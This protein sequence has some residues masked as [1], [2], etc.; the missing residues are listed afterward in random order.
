MDIDILKILQ[1]IKEA[2]GL[3]LLGLAIFWAVPRLAGA[4]DRN[5]RMI[6]NLANKLRI[7]PDSDVI[8]EIEGTPP[9]GHRKIT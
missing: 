2:G 6:Y 5:T 7:D 8:R 3:G 1:I 9:R 4:I